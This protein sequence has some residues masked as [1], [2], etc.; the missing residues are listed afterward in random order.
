MPGR[1]GNHGVS[2]PG[3]KR[4][5]YCIKSDQVF[6]VFILVRIAVLPM[7]SPSPKQTA[8]R[9][10]TSRWR[11]WYGVF[12]V[13]ILAQGRGLPTQDVPCRKFLLGLH[14]RCEDSGVNLATG[15]LI[16]RVVLLL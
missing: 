2:D 14:Q 11:S 4:S 16:L 15:N 3:F 6:V 13:S 12:W 9:I 7:V 5:I 1:G 8:H 10:G